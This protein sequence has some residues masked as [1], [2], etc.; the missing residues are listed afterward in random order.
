MDVPE[1]DDALVDRIADQSD[2]QSGDRSIRD[3]EQAR[4][5]NLVALIRALKERDTAAGATVRAHENDLK[6]S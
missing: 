3:M 2:A 6:K 5:E 4:D 1:L